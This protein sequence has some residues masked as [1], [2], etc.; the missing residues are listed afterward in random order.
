MTSTP[1]EWTGDGL[2]LSAT[3]RA[4]LSWETASRP[5]HVGLVAVLRPDGPARTPSLEQIRAAIEPALRAEP[6]LTARLSGRRLVPAPD[7]DIRRHVR[8]AGAGA[9]VDA[10]LAR[11]LDPRLPLFEIWM[12]RGRPDAGCVTLVCK[13]H[14]ALT[15]GV[16]GVRLVESL[17]GGIAHPRIT[18]T[19][20]ARSRSRRSASA[21]GALRALGRLL[22][23]ALRGGPRTA[24]NGVAAAR[25]HTAL[26]CDL[27]RFDSGAHALGGT[28]NDAL[29]AA[30][31]GAL[32]VALAPAPPSVRAF[33]PVSL[34]APGERGAGNRIS[35][36]LVDL[37][38][39]ERDR[40]R[41]VAAIHAATTRAKR[42]GDAS[43]GR[44]LAGL[45]RVLG[46]W[47]ARV[48]M[49]LAAAR[50]SYQVVVTNVS[51]PRRG[52]SLAGAEL[53]SLTPFA[54]LFAGPRLAVA[55]VSYAGR[56][57]VGVTHALP[58]AAIADRF[59]EALQRELDAIAAG[60][61]PSPA[62][63]RSA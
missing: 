44:V 46:A 18:R 13:V 63:Q 30:V 49:A 32:A 59:T 10:L 3:D 53:V 21:R 45:A 14:H 47:T 48:G 24:L 58:S 60:V 2:A 22:G 23:R 29:L 54:P 33:C 50:R 40:G 52:L 51:G 5:M 57:H 39:A 17:L 36:W 28:R 26:A 55:A 9:S 34:R 56:L 37:P 43:A 61:E 15:D 7:F 6:R 31:T 20:T 41:A 11:P 1:R 19:A 27:E 38:L 62:L 8:D 16:S 25:R 35:L 42:G 12:L 4:F